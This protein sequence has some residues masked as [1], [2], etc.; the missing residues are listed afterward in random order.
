MTDPLSVW[1]T[2]SMCNNNKR[3]GSEGRSSR[4][5]TITPEQKLGPKLKVHYH[6][7]RYFMHEQDIRQNFS[8][9]HI[10]I[11]LKEKVTF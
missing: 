11:L 10:S 6:H 2:S 4:V 7:S 9:G 1:Q 8:L 5:S 3:T